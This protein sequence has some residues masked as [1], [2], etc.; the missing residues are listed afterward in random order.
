MPVNT[1]RLE[2]YT[3]RIAMNAKAVIGM[4]HS[5]GIQVAAATKVVCGHSAVT[6]ALEAGGADMLAD[7]RVRNL[8]RSGGRNQPPCDAAN[9]S[10]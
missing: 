7:S 5:H 8:R 3:E 10:P 6:H 1:P 9:S 2:I 4:C